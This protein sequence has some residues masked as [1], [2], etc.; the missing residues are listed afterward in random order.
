MASPVSVIAISASPE[1]RPP[2]SSRRTAAASAARSP[3]ITQVLRALVI[4]V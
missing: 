1:W 4:A 3:T 2:L